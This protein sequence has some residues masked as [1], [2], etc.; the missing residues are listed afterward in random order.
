MK[1][2]T[3]KTFNSLLNPLKRVENLF[4]SFFG[5]LVLLKKVVFLFDNFRVKV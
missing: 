2:I 4:L 5:I 1:K 3:N